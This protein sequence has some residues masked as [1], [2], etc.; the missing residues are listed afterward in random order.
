MARIKKPDIF[1]H[2]KMGAVDVIDNFHTFKHPRVLFSK[3]VK[4]TVPAD[5][6]FCD[7]SDHKIR[8]VPKSYVASFIVGKVAIRNVLLHC[9]FFKINPEDI[10]KEI[11]ADCEVIE[12]NRKDTK[13]V[14]LKFS[15]YDGHPKELR[16]MTIATED[17]VKKLESFSLPQARGA[18]INFVIIQK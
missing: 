2:S 18:R 13:T 17:N 14:Y 3:S 11:V 9:L 7:Y 5:G 12:V 4:I 15:K 8:E 10:G 6:I 1:K 16:H